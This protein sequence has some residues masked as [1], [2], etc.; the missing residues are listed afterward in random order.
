MII[1]PNYELNSFLRKLYHSTIQPFDD[2]DSTAAQLDNST[3]FHHCTIRRFDCSMIRRFDNP[4]VL[5][6]T[7]RRFDDSTTPPFHHSTIQRFEDPKTP[8]M[9]PSIIRRFDDSITPQ[10]HHSTIRLP[11]Y[12]T[13]RQLHHS[14]IQ[15]LHHSTIRRSKVQP[16]L[17]SWRTNP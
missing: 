7:I 4:T 17:K 14:T 5:H 2:D 1:T 3:I 12:S 13:I 10:F 8:P 11:R 9:H 15:K 6:S 16:R